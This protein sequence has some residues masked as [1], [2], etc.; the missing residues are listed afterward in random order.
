MGGFQITV[1]VFNIPATMHW[2][3]L[4]TLFSYHGKVVDAF[5]PEKTSR[6]GKRFGFV[7]FSNFLDAQRAISRLNGF[8]ILGNRIWVN[9]ARFNGRRVTW[10]KATSQRNSSSFKESSQKGVVDELRG[11]E[12]EEHMDVA[13]K[14]KRF[15]RELGSGSGGEGMN[16]GKVVQGH[17]EDEQLWKLQKCLVGEVASFCELKSLADRVPGMGLG[18]IRVK[19]IQGNHFLIEIPDD[20]LFEILKQ[21]EWSYLKEF[22]IHIAPWSE[23]LVFTER[24]PRIELSGVPV[25]CWNYETFKRIAGK[26]GTLVSMGENWSGANN[27]EKVEMLISISQVQKLDEIVLLEVGEVRFPVSIKEKGWSEVHKI[28]DSLSKKG[29]IQGGLLKVYRNRNRNRLL[30]WN[31]RSGRLEFET[32]RWMVLRKQFL[33]MKVQGKNVRKSWWNIMKVI[34]ML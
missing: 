31:R 4:W 8:V 27:Y 34:M 22:F 1:F 19:R 5:I 6:N 23:K 25:H 13:R 3:G 18:D 14:P 32:F 10:R 30:V 2:K 16:I 24:V 11:K 29:K 21:R 9:I 15:G 7:R 17:V 20:E 28:K 33:K 26:W 12:V